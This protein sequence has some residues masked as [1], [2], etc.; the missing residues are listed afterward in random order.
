MAGHT[1]SRREPTTRRAHTAR[2][3][4]HSSFRDPHRGQREIPAASRHPVA[5]DRERYIQVG[6]YKRRMREFPD[7]ER[8][9]WAVLSTKP[10]E[11][12][13]AKTGLSGDDV[14]SLIDYQSYQ[15]PYRPGAAPGPGN[16]SRAALC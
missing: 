2:D 12:E 9:L 15:H 7:K 1:R 6:S 14:L 3:G 13:I 10:F 11:R 8:E 16:S 5:F 4:G